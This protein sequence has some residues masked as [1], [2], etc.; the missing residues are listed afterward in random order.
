MKNPTI[1]AIMPSTGAAKPAADI[2]IAATG[3]GSPGIRPYRG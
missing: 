1:V 2:H 3:A